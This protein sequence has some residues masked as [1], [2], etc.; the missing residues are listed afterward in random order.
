MALSRKR[1]IVIAVSAVALLGIIIVISILAGGKDEP[2]VTTVIVRKR[3][4]LRST[5]TANGEVRPIQFVNMTSEVAG[6]IEEIFVKEGDLVTKGQ[7]LVRLDPTQL[8][9]NQQAQAAA[10][11]AAISDTQ[12]ARTQVLASQ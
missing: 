4:E 8:Q 10:L 12:N 11:Q 9:S 3:A 1:K 2:E 6:R 5:V 7:P